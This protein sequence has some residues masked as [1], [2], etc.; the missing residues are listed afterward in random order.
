MTS[1]KQKRLNRENRL[2][3]AI[4]GCPSL[5]ICMVTNTKYPC[6]W[7]KR[8]LVWER[9]MKDVFPFRPQGWEAK[10]NQSTTRK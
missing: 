3:V 10:E 9:F 1:W 2:W 8:K 5:P 4:E 6:C 7:K